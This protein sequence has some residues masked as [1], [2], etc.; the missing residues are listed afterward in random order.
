MRLLGERPLIEWAFAAATTIETSVP[1]VCTTDF[2]EIIEVARRY[3]IESIYREPHL[4]T[5]QA[6][7]V[8]VLNDVLAKKDS[9]AISHLV[10]LQ[11]TSPFTRPSTID[12]C[13]QL[14]QARPGDTII[15]A[16]K[17]THTHPSLLFSYSDVDSRC[18]EW[19]NTGE[20]STRRQDLSPYM[21]RCGCCYVI[22]KASIESGDIYAQSISFAEVTQ[23]EAHNI[24]SEFDLIMAQAILD[25]DVRAW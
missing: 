24:D 10:L 19:L 6:K 14:S 1:I 23:V 22:P 11:P 12:C 5:D 25:H 3:G 20:I 2:P 7:I 16:Y 8:D 17:N 4:A 21:T 18:I 13:I 9:S 15:C